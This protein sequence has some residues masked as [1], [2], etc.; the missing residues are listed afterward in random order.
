MRQLATRL[1]FFNSVLTII[2]MA[3]FQASPAVADLVID[4]FTDARN[5]R[6]TNDANFIGAPFGQNA[7]SGVGVAF[8]PQFNRPDLPPTRR[9]GTLVSRNVILTSGHRGATGEITFYATNDPN[10]ASVVRTITNNRITLDDSDLTAVVLDAPVPAG[11]VSYSFADEFFSGPPPVEEPTPN[12]NDD[13]NATTFRN[14]IVTGPT[15]PFIDSNG[16]GE[17]VFQVGGSA[18]VRGDTVEERIIDIAVGQNRVSG[19]IENTFSNLGTP[20]N[21]ALLLVEELSGDSD[22]V[23]SESLAQGGD[24]GGPVFF[25]DPSGNLVLLGVNSVIGQVT[26]NDGNGNE[27]NRNFSALGFVGNRAETLNAFITANAVPEPSSTAILLSVILSRILVRRR[28][29]SR[30]C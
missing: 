19:F 29:L 1:T 11:Y 7:F 8:T 18:T 3:I 17:L 10:G 4:G 28:P 9:F 25:Q 15:V 16:V 27:S 26:L 2:S 12:P 5:D 20:N 6:F 22:F 24:S 30:I 14:Q 13:P 23:G 21:D